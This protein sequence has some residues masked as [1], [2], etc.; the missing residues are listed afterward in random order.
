MVE[1]DKGG[2]NTKK[3]VRRL[4]EVAYVHQVYHKKDHSAL[5]FY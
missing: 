2:G 3:K 5:G 4:P 1:Q